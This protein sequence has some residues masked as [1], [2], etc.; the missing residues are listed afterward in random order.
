MS[1]SSIQG[2]SSY[3]NLEEAPFHSSIVT[4]I[5]TI[6]EGN[7]RALDPTAQRPLPRYT[8]SGL[9]FPVIEGVTPTSSQA[10]ARVEVH[11]HTVAEAQTQA[12]QQA[13]SAGGH[14][15]TQNTITHPSSRSQDAQPCPLTRTILERHASNPIIN[16]HSLP[17]NDARFV[18]RCQRARIRSAVRVATA[19]EVRERER[20][21]AE[22]EAAEARVL[23][24]HQASIE[25]ERVD[26]AVQNLA[27]CGALSDSREVLAQIARAEERDR[28]DSQPSSHVE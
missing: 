15:H 12:H 19:R 14:A 10:C 13:G 25:A 3:E 18:I 26:A 7:W 5:N 8:L 2:R 24:A 28:L 23:A 1:T 9:S 4:E 16:P 20:G 17:W 11:S 22:R 6:E 27:L 21:R